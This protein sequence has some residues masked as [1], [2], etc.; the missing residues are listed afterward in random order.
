MQREDHI[1]IRRLDRV[2]LEAKQLLA[3]YYEAVQVANRDDSG[4]LETMVTAA[5]S[6][7]WLAYLNEH[8]VGCVMLRQLRDIAGASECKR[9]YVR[10]FARG[11]GVADKLLD[12][13]EDHAVKVGVETIYLD[14]FTDLKA[15]VRLYERRGYAYCDRYNDN[16]QATLF[17]RK[18]LMRAKA[19]EAGL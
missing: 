14:S 11:R 8:P 1:S 6:G 2:E 7:L 5:Q 16:P 3:E 15:A 4:A 13:M 18:A 17:M 10:P 9:L 12:E 19:G